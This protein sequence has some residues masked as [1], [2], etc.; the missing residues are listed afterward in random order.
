M[1]NQQVTRRSP[2]RGKPSDKGNQEHAF[3]P[4]IAVKFAERYQAPEGGRS[5]QERYWK[6]VLDRSSLREF[7]EFELLPLIE[8]LSPDRLDNLIDKAREAD[9]DYVP[10]RFDLWFQLVCPADTDVD[11]VAKRLSALD[12]VETAYVMRPGPPPVSPADDPR[13]ANQGYLSAGP[14]G[15][16][17]EYAWGFLGGDGA[18]VGWVDMEQG[19]NLNHEDLSAAAITLMSGVNKAYR[20]HGTSVIGQIGMADNAL[21]GVGGATAATGRVISQWRTAASYNTADAILDAAANMGFGDVLLLEAQEYDPNPGGL[22]YWPVEIADANYDAIRLATALGIVVVEAGCN[23]G[24]D[25]DPY[26]SPSGANIFDRTSPDFRDSG[27]IMVG[28]ASAATPHARLSFSN[29]GSRIDCYAWGESID[30]TT[31]N[32]AGTDNTSYTTSFGG[33]SGAS[34]IVTSAA[35]IIQA[36]AEMTIG[37]RFS[38]KELRQIIVIDGTASADPATDRIGVMPDLRAII[39]GNRINLAPDLYMRDHIGDTGDPTAGTVSLSPDIILRQSA[40]PNPTAAFGEGSGTE[41]NPALSDPA[42]SGIDHSLYVRALNRGG[43]AATGV[44]VDLYWSPPVTL[45]TP[46]LWNPIGTATL[47]PLP[48]GNKIR[49]SDAVTWP[50]AEIPA[51]GHYCFVAVAGNSED[52]APGPAAF[53]D[54]DLFRT[55]VRN[56]NNVAWRNFNVESDPPSADGLYTMA[57]L[58]VGAFDTTRRFELESIGA[59]P[60]GSQ[61]MLEVPSWLAEAFR[62]RHFKAKEPDRQGRARILLNPHGIRRFGPFS[63]HKDAKADCHLRV[64]INEKELEGGYDFS[65]R[66]LYEGGEVGRV[67]WRFAPRAKA[68]V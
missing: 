27:A 61:A 56:N 46:N 63:L 36:I 65:I 30:T 15:I 57:F 6:A 18:G 31:T 68:T 37:Y 52:P 40:V 32:T 60:R 24:Y 55:F 26:V 9:P 22:Y 35:V 17:A 54:F 25:L 41:N 20:A 11:E 43:S 3:S 58:I 23:G 19:W 66:Q 21:G 12:A 33:T 28:A 59:L 64:A 62:V 53:A 45:L 44:S 16:D 1:A 8:S 13:F 42:A 14:N 4:R 51:P 34:P 2:G 39:T 7:G 5:L 49:V 29:Y 50:A 67:T 47:P 10:A 38:P 48:P